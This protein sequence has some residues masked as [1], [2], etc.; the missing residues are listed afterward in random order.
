MIK[1]INILVLESL[2]LLT[3]WYTYNNWFTTLWISQVIEFTS[4]Y[5]S[6][7]DCAVTIFKLFS[8]VKAGWIVTGNSFIKVL[9]LLIYFFLRITH[10][11][12]KSG[13]DWETEY[14]SLTFQEHQSETPVVRSW[15]AYELVQVE[16]HET[17][18][19]NLVPFSPSL[20]C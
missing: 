5:I 19:K 8:R 9:N 6:I 3:W 14:F 15:E 12:L 4:C 13:F 17:R 11:C 7:F 2:P 20:K 16:R 10:S 1:S 18:K